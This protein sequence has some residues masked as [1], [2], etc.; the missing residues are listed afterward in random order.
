MLLPVSQIVAKDRGR[1]VVAGKEV[2]RFRIGSFA[3]KPCRRADAGKFDI[4]NEHRLRSSKV[5]TCEW[6]SFK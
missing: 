5:S 2:E 6:A 1:A 3:G 4:A